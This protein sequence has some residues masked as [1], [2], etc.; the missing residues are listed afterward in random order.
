VHNVVI[1]THTGCRLDLRR[2]ARNLP[3]SNYNPS[4]FAAVIVRQ[5]RPYSTALMFNTGKVVCTG[6]NSVAA[7]EEALAKFIGML[8][9]LEMF[10]IAQRE[11]KVENIVGATGLVSPNQEVRLGR[12]ARGASVE[13]EP[14]LFPG[15]S[16][17]FQMEDGTTV[18]VIVFTTGKMILTGNQQVAHLD[19]VMTHVQPWLQ[20]AVVKRLATPSRKR[21]RASIK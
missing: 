9:D 19:E 2:I 20:S 10:D 7:A 17:R 15:L 8:R 13:Y 5:R 1:T 16:R 21:R 3:N 4:R 12:L 11:T 14:E 6:S 18:M